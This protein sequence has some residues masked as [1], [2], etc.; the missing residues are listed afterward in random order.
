MG[1]VRNYLK[2][3]LHAHHYGM[4]AGKMANL[5]ATM[6]PMLQWYI[7]NGAKV[8]VDADMG[9]RAACHIELPAVP[10]SEWYQ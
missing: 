8:T 5:T 6:D 4:R 7:D 2:Q 9:D 10:T 3:A 1:E